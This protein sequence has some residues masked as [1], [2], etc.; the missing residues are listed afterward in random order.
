MMEQQ[1]ENRLK[2]QSLLPAAPNALFRGIRIQML[3]KD[4]YPDVVGVSQ[5]A[6]TEVIPTVLAE[7]YPSRE[8][9]TPPLAYSRSAACF[10]ST[11]LSVGVP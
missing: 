5:C 7:V 6:R 11:F 1:Q 4:V 10:R 8:Q 9:G 3:V 2:D